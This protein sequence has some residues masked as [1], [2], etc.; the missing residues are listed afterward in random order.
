[1][2]FPRLHCYPPSRTGGTRSA[3]EGTG[4]SVPQSQPDAS[5]QGFAETQGHRTFDEVVIFLTHHGAR[6]TEQEASQQDSQRL[7]IFSVTSGLLQHHHCAHIT[8]LSFFHL[9]IER[10]L[11]KLKRAHLSPGTLL[12]YRWFWASA[13][14]EWGFD[15]ARSDIGVTGWLD[16]CPWSLADVGTSTSRGP[17]ASDLYPGHQDRI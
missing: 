5:R 6:W 16:A 12:N 4:G 14:L 3:W 15:S 1:M 10:E 7:T 17:L 13:G 8:A 11:L 9:S 2:G